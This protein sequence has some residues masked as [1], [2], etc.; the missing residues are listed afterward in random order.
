[1]ICKNSGIQEVND[2]IGLHTLRHTFISMLCRKGVDKMVIAKLVGQSDTEMI[3]R[4]YYHVMQEEMDAA[5]KKIDSKSQIE[6]VEDIKSPSMIAG[7]DV[8]KI[9]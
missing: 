3:E 4:V 6:S 5:I 8:D 2:E 1:M 7:I 9:A